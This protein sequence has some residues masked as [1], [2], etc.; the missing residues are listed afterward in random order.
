M[1]RN[2][3]LPNV[4]VVPY[5]DCAHCFLRAAQPRG[6]LAGSTEEPALQGCTS[7]HN[8]TPMLAGLSYAVQTKRLMLF[9]FHRCVFMLG[10]NHFGGKYITRIC[11]GNQEPIFLG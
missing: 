11:T 1:K 10:L 9:R 3:A 4:S 2:S 8:N 6:R 5:F 7:G